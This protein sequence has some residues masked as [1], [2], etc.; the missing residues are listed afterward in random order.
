MISWYHWYITWA[1]S[2]YIHIMEICKAISPVALFRCQMAFLVFWFAAQRTSRN[3]QENMSET[4][5]KRCCWSFRRDMTRFMVVVYK[6]S[7]MIYGNL[8]N[9]YLY[10]ATYVQTLARL[11]FCLCWYR[12][13]QFTW[14]WLREVGHQLVAAVGCSSISSPPNTRKSWSKSWKRMNKT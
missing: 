8:Y 11:I 5:P 6:W 7:M 1:L 2:W 13:I 14:A 10:S 3:G 4:R 9:V 12:L